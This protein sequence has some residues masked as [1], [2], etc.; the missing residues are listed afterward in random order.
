MAC[1]IDIFLVSKDIAKRTGE[2][3]A[4]VLP[5]VG[6]NHWP[7]FLRWDWSDNPIKK[8]FRFEKFWL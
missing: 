3:S 5:A 4:N 8:P 2:M 1:R 7:I 6:L